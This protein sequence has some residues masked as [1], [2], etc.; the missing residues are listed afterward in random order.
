MYEGVFI[1]FLL[2]AASFILVISLVE[3]IRWLME[4]MQDWW[5]YR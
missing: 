4:K 1:V 2:Y 5:C 3:I